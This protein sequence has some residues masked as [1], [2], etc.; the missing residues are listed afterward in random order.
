M[1][2]EDRDLREKFR[3][4]RAGYLVRFA[5]SMG[6]IKYREEVEK[7]G[8]DDEGLERN[9]FHH[10]DYRRAFYGIWCSPK[11]HGAF[12]RKNP[13][14]GEREPIDYWPQ[15]IYEYKK[16][17][18]K[19]WN[20][21]CARERYFRTFRKAQLM[22]LER[23]CSFW[24]E[25]NKWIEALKARDSSTVLRVIKKLVA[26]E[27]ARV[28]RS[29]RPRNLSSL[30][31]DMTTKANIRRFRKAKQRSLPGINEEAS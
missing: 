17:R 26:V 30:K 14:P 5:Y 28:K 22:H 25:C 18:K 6:W 19:T 24:D 27:A 1:E 11:E 31:D 3:K 9:N 29:R 2:K 21:E 8:L 12:H 20:S 10:V 15:V 16:W 4:M 7:A 13:L 23:N